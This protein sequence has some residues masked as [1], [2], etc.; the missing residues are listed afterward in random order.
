MPVD[1]NNPNLKSKIYLKGV[2]LQT[3]DPASGPQFKDYSYNFMKLEIGR[4]R[5]CVNNVWELYAAQTKL[6]MQIVDVMNNPDKQE[7]KNRIP[8]STQD[9]LKEHG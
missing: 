6:H 8:T 9:R 4:N 1:P 3:R 5:D 7:Q 2:R